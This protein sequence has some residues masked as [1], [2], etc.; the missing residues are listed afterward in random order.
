MKKNI[1]IGLSIG[2]FVFGVFGLANATPIVF[3]V[4]AFGNSSSGGTGLNTGISLTSGQ[5]FSASA[6]SGDLWSAGA[7][8]RWSNAD[9]LIG[10]WYATGTDDS[11]QSAGTRIGEAF[12]TWT[13]Q[14]LTAPYG[15]LVGELSGTF[16]LLGTDF[17]GNAWGNGDLLLYYWDSNNY[18][19]SEYISVT[20]NAGP[21]P[22]PEPSTFLLL[23]AGLIGLAFAARRR[24][25]A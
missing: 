19:N 21:A 6:D 20:I 15:S 14:G 8:P 24:R 16:A 3:D 17:I 4:Y 9:G 11:V 10:N 1:L 18:D 23:G 2:L 25:K 13:Q 22:V 5:E 12:S 7:L